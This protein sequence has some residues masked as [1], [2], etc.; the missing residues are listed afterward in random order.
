MSETSLLSPEGLNKNRLILK[1]H[2][3]NNHFYFSFFVGFQQSFERLFLFL[4]ILCYQQLENQ[5]HIYNLGCI[6]AVL[7]SDGL[8]PFDL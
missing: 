6:G 5:V 3:C 4:S 7:A 1:L 8:Q 2:S